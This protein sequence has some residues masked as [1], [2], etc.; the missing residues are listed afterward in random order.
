MKR[1]SELLLRDWDWLV[2]CDGGRAD[3]FREMYPM[4]LEGNYETVYNGGFG[5]TPNWFN[6]HFSGEYDCTLFHGGAPIYAY[7]NNP[8][9]YD[10]R[11][12][13]KSVA[14]WEDFE[15]TESHKT[16]P[17]HTVTEAVKKSDATRGVIRYLQPHNPYRA[18]PNI[19]GEKDARRQSHSQLKIAYHDNYKWVLKEIADKLIPI[20]DGDIVITSDH[21][22]CLGDCR[23]Y[24]HGHQHHKHDH[25][26]NVP[27]FE[28]EYDE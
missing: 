27:W 11:E 12:H 18:L 7:T 22:Q 16:C 4:F 20:L 15:W 5:F 28:V 13:F 14:P 2:I 21:G 19:Q 3:S 8:P 23:Q 24:L 9:N 10:E 17:P 26:V 1:Q 25:L 6:C